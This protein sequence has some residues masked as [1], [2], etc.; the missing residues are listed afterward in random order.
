MTSDK[1]SGCRWSACAARL[2]FDTYAK[3]QE[4]EQI[5]QTYKKVVITKTRMHGKACIFYLQHLIMWKL[6]IFR[7]RS[8]ILK[9]EKIQIIIIIENII[10]MDLNFRNNCKLKI[11]ILK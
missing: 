6:F 5:L 7:I 2:G 3:K 9:L 4:C 10:L 1:T 11:K 8:K